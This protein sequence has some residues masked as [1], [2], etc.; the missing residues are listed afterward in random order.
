[1]KDE[2]DYGVDFGPVCALELP[3]RKKEVRHPTSRVQVPLDIGQQAKL[4]FIMVHIL[5]C[6]IA[7]G[8]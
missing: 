3:P 5:V 4:A 1:M 7:E 2:P 6:R 8:P